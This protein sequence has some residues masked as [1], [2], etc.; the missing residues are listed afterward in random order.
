MVIQDS[1][2]RM[3]I[4]GITKSDYQTFMEFWRDAGTPTHESTPESQG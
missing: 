2:V 1:S 3:G 4:S